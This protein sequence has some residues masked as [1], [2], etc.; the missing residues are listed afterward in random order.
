[1]VT[2]KERLV[3]LR[4]VHEATNEAVKD[5]E[6]KYRE[7]LEDNLLMRERLINC[8]K[9]LDI[10]KEIMRNALIEQNAIKDSYGREIA[11]LRE[12]IK[13]LNGNNNKLGN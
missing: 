13:V 12:K 4:R 7:V 11:E 10:T 6:K 2:D 3:S 8:Q 5:L 1:M 9:S